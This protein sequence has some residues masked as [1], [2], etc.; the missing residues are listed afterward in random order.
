MT[1]CNFK[2]EW[3]FNK[4]SPKNA[5][6][7]QKTSGKALILINK[8]AFSIAAPRQRLRR[9]ETPLKTIYDHCL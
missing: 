1:V 3:S 9:V 5:G 4:S 2:I 7:R 8:T 6:K